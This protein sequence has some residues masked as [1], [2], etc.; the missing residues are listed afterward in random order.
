MA[1][2][3]RTPS[4]SS[5]SGIESE[6][7]ESLPAYQRGNMALERERAAAQGSSDDEEDSEQHDGYGPS[8]YN[9]NRGIKALVT[10]VL[11]LDPKKKTRANQK[12][13]T[14]SCILYFHEDLELRDWLVKLLKESIA[15]LRSVLI[16]L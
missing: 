11:F 4:E 9:D 8:A 7:E 2:R 1:Q 13:T 10:L 14:E 15:S 16:F 6:E 3:R 5:S 12:P